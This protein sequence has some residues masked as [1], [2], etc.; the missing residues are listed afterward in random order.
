MSESDEL[1]I[2]VREI[3]DLLQLLAEPAVAERDSK[4]RAELKTI[5]GSSGPKSKA[6]LLMDGTRPQRQIHKETGMN[7][8]NLSTLVKKLKKSGL[9]SDAPNPT[10]VIKIPSNFFEP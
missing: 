5:V 7:Q 1:L 4:L 3:R 2:A 6:V 9:L 8:G 10:F